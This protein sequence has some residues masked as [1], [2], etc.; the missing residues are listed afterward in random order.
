M[1][2]MTYMPKKIAFS[3]TIK[4]SEADGLKDSAGGSAMFPK[5]DIQAVVQTRIHWAVG[6]SKIAFLQNII[7][8]TLSNVFVNGFEAAEDGGV[9]SIFYINW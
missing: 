7:A 2:K 6:A 9:D 8:E 4:N 5:T 3:N 1:K